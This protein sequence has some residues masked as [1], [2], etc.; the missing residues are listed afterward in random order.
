[1]GKKLLF[2]GLF[3]ASLSLFYQAQSMEVEESEEVQPLEE[4]DQESHGA[5]APQG[6]LGQFD[7]NGFQQHLA[8]LDFSQQ[9]KLFK[10]YIELKQIEPLK[11][12]LAKNPALAYR[13]GEFGKT[14]LRWALLCGNTP[15]V[16]L[17][18]SRQSNVNTR[19]NAENFQMA[20]KKQNEHII[21]L[22]LAHGA[23][24]NIR[25]TNPL[26][27]AFAYDVLKNAKTRSARATADRIILKLVKL[28][29]EGKNTNSRGG[30]SVF[31]MLEPYACFLLRVIA[32]QGDD[33]SLLERLCKSSKELKHP[34]I[35]DINLSDP[36]GNTMLHYAVI[37]N[38]PAILEFVLS[39]KELD[40]NKANKLGQTA[41]A[42]AQE[43]GNNIIVEALMRRGATPQVGQTMEVEEAEEVIIE[44][45]VENDEL[46]TQRVNDL[47]VTA[48]L[49]AQIN[50]DTPALHAL[51]N[52]ETTQGMIPEEAAV[53]A[54]EVGA[55]DQQED[56]AEMQMADD[57][58]PAQ[59]VIEIDDTEDTVIEEG[60]V[61][62]TPET[63]RVFMNVQA[64]EEQEEQTAQ[65]TLSEDRPP[66]IYGNQTELDRAFDLIGQ[67]SDLRSKLAAQRIII[68]RVKALLKDR[69]YSRESVRGIIQPHRWRILCLLALHGDD[70][71]LVDQLLQLTNAEKCVDDINHTDQYG[72][73]VLHFA[74]QFTRH[75]ILSA[76][77][78]Y[79]EL[80][81]DRRNNLG[82]TPLMIAA[83]NDDIPMIATL[84]GAGANVNQRHPESGENIFER[85]ALSLQSHIYRSRNKGTGNSQL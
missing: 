51:T 21:D 24:I 76:L 83:M 9:Q 6:F 30:L 12:M 52:R 65:E 58:P 68:K 53:R 16:E 62:L 39:R 20:I 5:Y 28:L 59:A 44:R 41:L 29:L 37:F 47:G 35:K 77:L 19:E 4:P 55:V 15:I 18:L 75:R 49:M 36:A 34:L 13:T 11:E 46:D 61:Q 60:T 23:H 3:L 26:Q 57:T 10:E 70:S 63:S 7:A 80:A 43:K 1:M 40:V 25:S 82:L 50:D 31:R 38:R 42:I 66:I 32:A 8:S 33:A 56:R 64:G 17:L 78:A 69:A 79:K 48:L 14:A 73:S 27:C 84:F 54:Q 81:L 74:A 67:A 85:C 22:F 2:L 72:N 45:K 71:S